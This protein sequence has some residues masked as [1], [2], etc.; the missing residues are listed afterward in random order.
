MPDCKPPELEAGAE[1]SLYWFDPA[2][3]LLA[4]SGRPTIWSDSF[5]NSYDFVLD[6]EEE[7]IYSESYTVFR[8]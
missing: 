6:A 8:Q 4:T 1:K 2:G 7:T 3:I 5:L